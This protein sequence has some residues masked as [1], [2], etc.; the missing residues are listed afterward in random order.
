[1]GN[2][3]MEKAFI[4]LHLL[5]LKELKYGRLKQYGDSSRKMKVRVTKPNYHSYRVSWNF[6]A[7]LL[8]VSCESK[9][10]DEKQ[11]IITSREVRIYQNQNGS[12]VAK[13][14][15]Q[16]ANFIRDMD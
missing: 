8:A 15:I 2:S 10:M 11:A 3:K 6:L 7:N 12:W 5:V 14:N 9:K 13:G 16:V 4:Q 1:M